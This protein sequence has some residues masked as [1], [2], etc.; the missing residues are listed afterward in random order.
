MQEM[1]IRK[2]FN[3]TFSDTSPDV[4]QKKTE[5][6]E[7]S[8]ACSSTQHCFPDQPFQPDVNCIPV[9]VL[10]NRTLK[11]HDRLFKD[12]PWL[13]FDERT[14]G[15]LCYTCADASLHKLNQQAHCSEETFVST[16][17]RNWKKAIQK[18]RAHEQSFAH[19]LSSE[20]L[21]VRRSQP[22]VDVQLSNKLQEEQSSARSALLK[23]ISSLQYLA[24]QGIAI[25]G[26]DA[27]DGNFKSL[28]QLRAEDDANLAAWLSR[29]T[30]YT[31]GEIQ[32]ELL[33][34]M[35]HAI[36]RDICNEVTNKSA[37][38]GLVV[39]GTQDIQGNEQ[40]SVCIRHV[41]DSFCVQEDFIGLYQVPSTTGTSL[42]KMLQ[43]VLIRCQLPIEN[44]RAQTYD[45]ASNM[46][47]KFKG[48][49]AEIK[50]LQPLAIY[51]HCG[52]HVTQIVTSKAV[53]SAPFIRDALDHVQELGTLYSQSGKLKHLY[54]NM[55][56]DDTDIPCPTRLK[57]ICPTRWLTRA[58]AVKSVLDNYDAVLD[59]LQQASDDFGTNTASRARGIRSCL[60]SG[61]CVLGLFA[62]LPVLQSM[63]CFNKALQGSEVTVSGMLA[64]AKVTTEKLQSL[65]TDKKFREMFQQ[66]QQ[67]LDECKLDPVTLPRKRKLPVRLDEGTHEY[68]P[69]SAEEVYRVE[70][71]KVIDSAL[72]NLKEYFTSTDLLAYSDLTDMLLSGLFNPE[73]VKKYPELLDSLEQELSFFRNQYECTNVEEYRKTFVNMVPEVRRMFPQVECLLRL[74]LVC[75][76][77]SCEAERSFSALRRLKTW[78]RATMSQKR[79]NSVMICHVHRERVAAMDPK[80]IAVQFLCGVT[81]KRAHI[82]GK[83]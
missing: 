83:F 38:F 9:Q 63:E 80:D 52:A 81:D 60:S 62:S 19:R 73:M 4:E 22:G 2:F 48:C 34:L 14:G 74:L 11:F 21:K 13:H 54:L 70:Y 66:T 29:K 78:L 61:K 25:R 67:R 46:S 75:P 20:N 55:H 23:I 10:P 32:N 15:V 36:V 56:T 33:E 12:Y 30:T 1:D 39:D 47:G 50:K 43:D 76:A 58:P 45:G 68:T 71:F 7:E 65:R 24:Q 26:K 57:P 27:S 64:A 17:F 18:F 59:A 41:T 6:A 77:S 28:L 16:G 79:L 69:S 44:L 42:S 35:S 51:V 31:C 8:A 5:Q 3:T 49:Q 37:K 40:E 53:Q 72:E 82:F